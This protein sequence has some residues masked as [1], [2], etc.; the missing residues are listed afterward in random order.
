M[1]YI[2]A[3]L[4]VYKL[5]QI[6]DSLTPK[7]A[8]PWVKIVF[9]V[10]VGYLILLFVDTEHPAIDGLVIATLAGAVHS[11]LRLATLLGDLAQRKSTR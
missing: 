9:T 7:E 5:V 2:F 11:L 6:A 1:T 8:M 3:A 4:A 10:A